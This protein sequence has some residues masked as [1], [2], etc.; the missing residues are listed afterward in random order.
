MHLTVCP[1]LWQP[2]SANCWKGTSLREPG[3][4]WWIVWS[5]AQATNNIEKCLLPSRC[6]L[7]V[8][9]KASHRGRVSSSK[10]QQGGYRGRRAQQQGSPAALSTS[11]RPHWGPQAPSESFILLS[12]VTPPPLINVCPGVFSSEAEAAFFKTVLLIDGGALGGA[13][14]SRSK[15][16]HGAFPHSSSQKYTQDPWGTV[17]LDVH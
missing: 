4:Q 15:C 9:Y 8:P 16:W 11:S 6:W 13:R 3:G 5:Q 2:D 12:A 7:I 14:S 1:L 10:M 17:S